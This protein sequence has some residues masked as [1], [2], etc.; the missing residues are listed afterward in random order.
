[1][2][3]TNKTI[4]AVIVGALLGAGAMTLFQ[5]EHTAAEGQSAES[6]ETKPLTGLRLWTQIIVAINRVSHRWGW[7]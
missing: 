6:G 1:M 4:I 2:S 7:I 5:G 3:A